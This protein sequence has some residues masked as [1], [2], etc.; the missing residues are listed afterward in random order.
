MLHILLHSYTT[1]GKS[2]A[3]LERWIFEKAL[4]LLDYTKKVFLYIIAVFTVDFE[5]PSSVAAERTAARLLMM[6]AARSQIRSSIFV[7]KSTTPHTL[8][9]NVYENA[10]R[11]MKITTIYGIDRDKLKSALAMYHVLVPAKAAQAEFVNKYA[12][13]PTDTPKAGD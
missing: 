8:V 4:L 6:Y 1:C 7:Y 12:Y 3:F 2:A 9:F 10:G 5:M 13:T 11:Y